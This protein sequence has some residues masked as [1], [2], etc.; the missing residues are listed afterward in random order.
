[1]KTLPCLLAVLGLAS[2][3]AAQIS[4]QLPTYST[5]SVN[6][7]VVVPDRGGMWSGGGGQSS[8]GG[9]RSAPP[10]QMLRTVRQGA[11]R[12][13]VT[14]WIHDRPALDRATLDRAAA[15]FGPSARSSKALPSDAGAPSI[16]ALRRQRAAEKQQLAADTAA[17]LD[18]ARVVRAAR[19][20]RSVAKPPT[21]VRRAAK[22]PAPAVDR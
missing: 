7:T 14:A 11:A 3:A 8:F 19:I 16:S 13:G 5:F 1:M 15:P 18:A 21:E 12:M 4:V 17:R 10:G 22:P 9:L 20:A 2:E 6:T